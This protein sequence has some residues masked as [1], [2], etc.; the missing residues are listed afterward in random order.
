MKVYEEDFYKGLTTEQENLETVRSGT[1]LTNSDLQ[2]VAEIFSNGDDVLIPKLQA[3]IRELH[4]DMEKIKK[5]EDAEVLQRPD[6]KKRKR[7]LCEVSMK[8]ASR[9]KL[10]AMRGK[11]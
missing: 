3:V 8:E 1:I 9:E 7:D 2:K 5:S 6:R 10:G 11:I 4:R